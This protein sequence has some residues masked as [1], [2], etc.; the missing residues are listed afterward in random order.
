MSSTLCCL[1]SG[2]SSN[3]HSK[4]IAAN[5]RHY[6]PLSILLGHLLKFGLLVRAALIIAID[7]GERQTQGHAN[8][9]KPANLKLEKSQQEESSPDEGSDI[10]YCPKDA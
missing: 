6:S 2:A 7:V 9:Q 10:E 5:C 1:W 4:E 3:E 8:N